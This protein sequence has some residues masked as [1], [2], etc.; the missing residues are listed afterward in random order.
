VVL[1]GAGVKGGQ[2]IGATNPG[3]DE[4][5]DRPVSVPDLFQTFC[6]AL[7]IDPNF[8]NLAGNGRP[9]KIVEKGKAVKELFV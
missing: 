6:K 5:T 9:I 8:E 3:G 2:V 1:G 7:K 4:V